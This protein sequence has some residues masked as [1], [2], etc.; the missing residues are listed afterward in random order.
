MQP[1]TTRI[2]V[3]VDN[4]AEAGLMVAHGFALWIETA[5]RHIL[6]DTGEGVAC[7]KNSWTLG[8]DLTTTDT[9]VLSHGHNDHTGGVSRCLSLAG[10][11]ELYCHPGA[12]LPR[13]SLRDNMAKSLQMPREAMRAID[14]LP[15]KRVHWVQHPLVL[16]ETIGLTGPIPRETD[17]E[18]TGGPFFLDPKGQRPD[19]I[20]DDLALWIRTDQGLIVCVGC[21]HA[22]LINTLHHVQRLN[23]GLRIRAVISGFH[24]LNA[25]ESRLA[26]TIAALRLIAPEQLIPCHCTG[27]WAVS[28]LCQAFPKTCCPGMSGRTYTF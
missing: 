24:L 8:V 21:A 25:D 10:Q 2:T 13:F 19:P 15:A 22:G 14:K 16:T 23:Q 7:E 5:H 18:D 3:L 9:L 27:E 4:Q 12:V 6:F 1:E 11:A 20:N 17:F 26:Q 28:Q